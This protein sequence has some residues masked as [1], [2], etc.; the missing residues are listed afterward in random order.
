MNNQVAMPKIEV[1]ETKEMNDKDY[2]TCLLNIEK[3][4]S[5]NLNISLNEAS[6]EVLYNK[7]KLIYDDVRLMQRKI[8]ELAFNLGWY[9]LEKAESTKISEK[10]NQLTNEFNQL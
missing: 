3:N 10:L 9:P 8:Y 7:L 6:N 5:T 2:I 4:M 1:A